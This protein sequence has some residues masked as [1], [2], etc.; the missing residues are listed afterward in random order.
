MADGQPTR[1]RAHLPRRAIQLGQR[2]RRSRARRSSVLAGAFSTLPFATLRCAVDAA[3]ER[4]L[5]YL[6]L[7]LARTRL[8]PDPAGA[9]A[10][11]LMCMEVAA[12]WGTAPRWPT[13]MAAETVGVTRLHRRCASSRSSTGTGLPCR[14]CLLCWS[15]WEWFALPPR[16]VA[17]WPCLAWA[18]LHR[19]SQCQ[20]AASPRK[21]GLEK[22]SPSLNKT[23]WSSLF[24]S[25]SLP[26][27]AVAHPI[28]HTRTRS[29]TERQSLRAR[30]TDSHADTHRDTHG[31]KPR[32]TTPV[33]L[34]SR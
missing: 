20:P 31:E 28:D 25:S 3:R 11:H 29:E 15:R 6:G 2:Q 24:C 9:R 27:V 32:P 4:N 13:R 21:I 12:W 18:G 10:R 34:P 1:R 23:A 22:P 19:H 16:R 30:H 26:P 33:L 17:P 5:G 8:P 14:R 7:P